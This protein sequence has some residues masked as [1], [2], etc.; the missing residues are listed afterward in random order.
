MGPRR[1]RRRWPAS[2]R[3]RRTAGRR[4]GRSRDRLLGTGDRLR[5][6]LDAGRP[7]P[8]LVGNRPGSITCAALGA[9]APA[10][11]VSVF[12]GSTATPL[13]AGGA[14]ERHRELVD[15][16]RRTSRP[17]TWSLQADA[18]VPF[19][20]RGST[21][22]PRSGAVG[23][24]AVRPRESQVG[25]P[26]ERPRTAAV[27]RW[28]EGSTGASSGLRLPAARAG[29]AARRRPRAPHPV[30]SP[31]QAR[32]PAAAGKLDRL[33]RNLAH[34]VNAVQD[35]AAHGVRPAVLVSSVDGTGAARHDVLIER[36][37][38]RAG[39]GDGISHRSVRSTCRRHP[40]PGPG[41][42]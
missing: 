28:G 26:C 31:A 12:R 2:C 3:S 35:L 22:A 11:Q 7:G 37:R 33:G 34:L 27:N 32:Q 21:T 13:R 15:L 5:A 14:P 23:G 6:P 39:R 19:T 18:G 20:P 30:A 24:R 8:A 25:T 41:S 9:A 38:G 16:G 40:I 29:A 10:L 17:P 4:R 42:G 1:A 36:R